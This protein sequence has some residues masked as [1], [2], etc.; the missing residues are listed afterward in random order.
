M[1]AFTSWIFPP[2]VV[3]CPIPWIIVH[4]IFKRKFLE[5]V[6]APCPHNLK[7]GINY[8]LKLYLKVLYKED[9]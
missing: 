7:L 6:A 9:L 1:L 2:V 4:L 8:I 5:A 3:I